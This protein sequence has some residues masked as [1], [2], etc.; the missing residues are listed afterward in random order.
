MWSRSA[1]KDNAKV[2]LKRCYWLAFAVT[3]VYTVLSGGFSVNI[4]YQGDEHLRLGELL[5]LAFH[6]F[7]TGILGLLFAIFIVSAIAVGMHRFFIQARNE[8][9]DFLT[10]FSALRGPDYLNVIKT[11]FFR[12]LYTFLWSLLFVIPGI[13]KY[14]SYWM[15]PFLLA[16]NPKM[17]TKR[18]FEISMAV[19]NGE[20]W[21]MFVLDL[22]FLGWL[23][24][25]ALCLGVGILFVLPYMEATYVELYGVLRY[26]A[27]AI[28]V[29][30]PLELGDTLVEEGYA[31]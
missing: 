22:S 25:G 14:Y 18:A 23:F 24:L 17:D 6:S 19:T 20:K 7:S 2:V 26:K 31:E 27:I 28:G 3:A 8:T 16:E 12:G 21:K 30:S 11:M 29:C 5:R 9:P 4:R 13:V 10:L 15:V 1:L